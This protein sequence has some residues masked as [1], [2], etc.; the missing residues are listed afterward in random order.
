MMNEHR[1]LKQWFADVE[2][3]LEQEPGVYRRT[4]LLDGLRRA[5]FRCHIDPAPEFDIDAFY[6][7]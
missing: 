7:D 2:S 6:P 5:R 3:I 1:L 4:Y